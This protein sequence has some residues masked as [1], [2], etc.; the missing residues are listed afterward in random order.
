MD[1]DFTNFP[2]LPN[3]SSR[4]LYVRGLERDEEALLRTKGY[5]P[6]DVLSLPR[7]T[8][9]DNRHAIMCW[10]TG[11]AEGSICMDAERRKTL[12]LEARAYGMLINRSM[13]LEAKGQLEPETIEELLN[14]GRSTHTLQSSTLSGM[15]T[16]PKK[17]KDEILQD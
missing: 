15:L 14:L 8:D 6:V 7:N 3:E 12:E 16:K 17:E 5:N 9:S 4:T 10:I 1:V 13:R 11:M 2:D